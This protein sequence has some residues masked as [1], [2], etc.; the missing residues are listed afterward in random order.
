ME[1]S[2]V[3]G[4]TLGLLLSFGAGFLSGALLSQSTMEEQDS[5]QPTEQCE[6]QTLTMYCVKEP[7]E[8]YR[9]HVLMSKIHS[10]K[11]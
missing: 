2:M 10:L 3:I 1:T 4:V 6:Y 11:E 7:H 5:G 9:P 8:S